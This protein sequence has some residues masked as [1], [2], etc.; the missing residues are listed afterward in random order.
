MKSHILQITYLL[1][2]LSACVSSNSKSSLSPVEFAKEINTNEGIILD[3]RTPEE[4]LNGHLENAINVDWNSS[5]FNK[6][7]NTFGKNQRIYVYCLSGGRSHSA[8][9]NL[10]SSGFTNVF[11]LNGGIL[12][13]KSEGLPLTTENTSRNQG[14]SI[15]QFEAELKKSTYTIVDFNAIWCAPC[16]KLR[17]LLD[18]YI[19]KNE[20]VRL[21]AI[22]V[23]I[24]PELVKKFAVDAIPRILVYKGVEL[25]KDEKGLL[26]E[27]QVNRLI[28]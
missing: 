16:K 27:E 14:M 11:E 1:F 26:T 13:W 25:I 15:L 10:R 7:I 24:N 4:F 28:P 18:E 12:K 21:L 22:D 2:V 8:A 19:R 9:E 20:N 6:E 3:V 5:N 17:P 23:D